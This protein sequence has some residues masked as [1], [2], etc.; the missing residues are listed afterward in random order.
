MELAPGLEL[1]LTGVADEL[2][3]QF[4]VIVV[5]EG[6]ATG[7]GRGLDQCLA[8]VEG[9]QPLDFDVDFLT[10]LQLDALLVELFGQLRVAGIH[11]ASSCD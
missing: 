4:L 9:M 7:L 10:G 11:G 2:P 8:E 5:P 3:A 6:Y 1:L